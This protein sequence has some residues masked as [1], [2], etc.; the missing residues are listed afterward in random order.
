M[1]SDRTSQPANNRGLQDSMPSVFLGRDTHIG[2]PPH[3]SQQNSYSNVAMSA[4]RS[5]SGNVRDAQSN[6]A[7]PSGNPVRFETRSFHQAWQDR[8]QNTGE[9]LFDWMREDGGSS[10]ASTVLSPRGN[11]GN[12]GGSTGTGGGSNGIGGSTYRS[13]HTPRQL[14][15]YSTGQPTRPYVIDDQVIAHG[16]ARWYNVYNNSERDEC[17][18]MRVLE[19]VQAAGLVL[20][21]GS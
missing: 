21:A 9:Y 17:F 3:R 13:L 8:A 12:R 6:I 18:E 5:A 10:A 15:V 4:R 7:N 14:Q 16:G 2:S 1:S 20:E 19:H 11:H